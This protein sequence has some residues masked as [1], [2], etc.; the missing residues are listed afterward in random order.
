MGGER[1]RDDVVEL[2][3]QGLSVSQVY[4]VLKFRRQVVPD[5]KQADS[6]ISD[7]VVDISVGEPKA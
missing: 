7:V 5:E 2:E 3:C 4:R 1:L 6:A